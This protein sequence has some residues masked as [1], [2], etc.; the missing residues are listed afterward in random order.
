MKN[1]HIFD[2]ICHFLRANRL[3]KETDRYNP[4]ENKENFIVDFFTFLAHFLHIICI[5]MF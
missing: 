3:E 2:K 1:L 5:R 4:T